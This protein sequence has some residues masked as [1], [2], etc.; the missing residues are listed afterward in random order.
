M[1]RRVTRRPS[2]GAWIALLTLLL[3][4]ATRAQGDEPKTYRWVGEDG[5]VYTSTTPPPNGRGAIEVKP[6]QPATTKSPVARGATPAP[7]A[8][9]ADGES[10][11]APYRSWVEEWRA[12]TRVVEAAET[13]LDR[14]QSD[15]DDYV[16]RNDSYYETQLESAEDRVN[17]AQQRLSQVES[18]A[19]RAGIPQSCFT[20]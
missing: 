17:R 7:V 20:Q 18:D 5:H 16:R 13:S 8:N 12:A 6:A 1:S 19:S 10:P 15:T 3:T 9:G 11:C 2:R 14:L 4:A